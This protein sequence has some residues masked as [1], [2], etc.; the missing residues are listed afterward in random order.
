LLNFLDGQNSWDKSIVIATTNYPHTLPG[1]IV[2][3]PSRFDRLYK[4][5]CPTEEVRR[6]YLEAKLGKEAVTD[7]LIKGTK[8]YSIAHLREL[9]VSIPIYGQDPQTRLAEIEEVKKLVQREFA[10]NPDRAIGFSSE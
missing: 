10:E 7:E 3:R 6:I 1:N 8:G 4:V 5:D 2:D 9:V